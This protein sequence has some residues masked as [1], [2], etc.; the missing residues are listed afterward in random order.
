VAN[1][2]NEFIGVKLTAKSA[3][4]TKEAKQIRVFLTLHILTAL[5]TRFM[6]SGIRWL[7]VFWRIFLPPFSWSKKSA[8]AVGTVT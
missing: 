3:L 4:F 1:Y 8:K 7:S 2:E 6:S 5:L